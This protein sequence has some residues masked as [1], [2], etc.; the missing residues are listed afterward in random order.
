MAAVTE[1]H[2]LRI[3][4]APPRSASP[5]RQR[6]QITIP[7]VQR[8]ALQ[9]GSPRAQRNQLN[10]P[11]AQK[12]QMSSYLSPVTQGAYITLVLAEKFT[13]FSGVGVMSCPAYWIVSDEKFTVIRPL[14]DN[15]WFRPHNVDVHVTD[16]ETLRYEN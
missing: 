10:S 12:L 5:A 11:R 6:L 1:D 8:L 16:N 2:Q 14:E 3:R 9:M 7:R 13:H 15:S 4:T